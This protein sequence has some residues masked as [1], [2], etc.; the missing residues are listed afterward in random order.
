LLNGTEVDMNPSRDI[1]PPNL[2]LVRTLSVLLLSL[3]LP[4]G[5]GAQML[6]SR[7][8]KIIVGVPSGSSIDFVAR[9]V[10]EQMGEDSGRPVIVENR[11][12]AGGT[13]AS[14][15]FSRL[16]AD[17]ST[18]FVSGIDAIVYNFVMTDRRPL[19]PFR[20]FVP[21]GRITRDHWMLTTSPELKVNSV[22]EL[23]V[24]GKSRPGG[25]HYASIGTGS[26]VHLLGERFR[27]LVNIEGTHV[28][29]KDS[30]LPDLATGRV[31]YI[32]HIT[33]AVAP[34][35]RT[36]KLKGLAVLSRERLGVFPDIQTASESGVPDLV[37]N[38]GVVMYAPGGASSEVV[39]RL[40]AALS[41]AVSAESVQRRFRDLEVET[42]Q[43]T[44]ADATRYITELMT[45]QDRLR[46]A[47]FGRAR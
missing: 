16:L 23:V 20:D 39:G 30:Y 3:L 46:M 47:V 22:S 36:G 21:I 13:I 35:I 6:S 29:Y 40:S 14:E 38:G 1:N 10:A 32:V 24:L 11:P 5:S 8:V 33:A 41:K 44:P 27:Q 43:G 15:A 26:T 9:A 31:S 45:L 2:R 25:L 18:L 42:V 12:G 37:Y 19:D 34:H 28:P 7:P 17:G 4:V